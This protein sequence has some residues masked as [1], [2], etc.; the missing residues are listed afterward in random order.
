MASDSSRRRSRFSAKLSRASG[1]KAAPGI[2]SPSIKLELAHRFE[3][4]RLERKAADLVDGI[5]GAGAGETVLLVEH[6]SGVRTLTAR[7]LGTLG[8]AVIEASDGDSAVAAMEST[9]RVDLLLT[10][11]VLPGAM[12]GPQ[13][14]E[15]ARRR[16]SGI[17]V[18][19][20]SGYPDH[21]LQHQDQSDGVEVLAK[22]FPKREL[23]QKVRSALD[24][25]I[26][27]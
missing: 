16:N 11:I 14:A 17:K 1:K 19:F 21:L 2:L 3:K 23:A 12:S 25:K 7:L 4:A 27:A 24:S 20:M 5:A 15:E 26:D 18:L 10:D 6:V 8:Y 22:P 13:I 9:F